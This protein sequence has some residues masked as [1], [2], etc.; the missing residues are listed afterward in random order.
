MVADGTTKETRG[1]VRFFWTWLFLATTVSVAGNVAH[2]VLTAPPGTVRLAAAA[3]VVPPAVLL[4]ATHSV[5]LLVKTRRVGFVYWLALAMTFALAGC[6]F[7]LSF[8]ALRDLA[9]ALGMAPSRAWLWPVAIDVSI[10]NSTLSLLSLSPP[11]S[12]SIARSAAGDVKE[13]REVAPTAAL[14][15]AQAT[16]AMTFPPPSSASGDQRPAPPPTPGPPSPVP[17]TRSESDRAPSER[18]NRS[19][20]AVSASPAAPG[21]GIDI[22]HWRLAADQLVRDGVTSKDPAIVAAVL[23]EKA[24]GT[25]PSTISRRHNLHH[26]TVGRILEGHAQRQGGPAAAECL[27]G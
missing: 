22:K 15:S 26:S 5:A 8:D 10:A 12:E 27:T 16:P 13:V 24:A 25:A 11:R 19:L 23:A 1:A 6:A 7:I 17:A 2:A 3:A 14:P 20:A 9:V 21:D 4:G 18:V